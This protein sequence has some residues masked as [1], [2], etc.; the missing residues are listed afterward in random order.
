METPQVCSRHH[1]VAL[2]RVHIHSHRFAH[3]QFGLKPPFVTTLWSHG[4]ERPRQSWASEPHDEWVV[5]VVGVTSAREP[6]RGPLATFTSTFVPCLREGGGNSPGYGLLSSACPHAYTHL[7][8]RDVCFPRFQPQESSPTPG[9]GCCFLVLCL[10]LQP[11][12]R[13]TG[14]IWSTPPSLFI[15][16]DAFCLKHF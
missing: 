13:R 14:H 6:T 15:V 16:E 12:E 3:G 11:P 9:M 5:S 8:E 2:A 1:A 4:S 10:S 7:G